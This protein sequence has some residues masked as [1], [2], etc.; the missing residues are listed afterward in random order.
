MD[1]KSIKINKGK[2]TYK[3][4][5]SNYTYTSSIEHFAADLYARTLNPIFPAASGKWYYLQEVFIQQAKE[6]IPL[7]SVGYYSNN[8]TKD[9]LEQLDKLKSLFL[10]KLSKANNIPK[11]KSYSV[12]LFDEVGCFLG[13]TEFIR[14]D[15]VKINKHFLN[16]SDKCEL[17]FFQAFATKERLG[18]R[19]AKILTIKEAA[20]FYK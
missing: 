1:I 13:C 3:D 12:A 15:S 18:K 9:Q 20:Q 5:F 7:S 10:V 2:V 11:T 17:T 4:T 19:A 14:K 8:K 6:T 16:Y